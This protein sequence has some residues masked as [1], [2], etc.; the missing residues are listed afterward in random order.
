MDAQEAAPVAS[1]LMSPEVIGYVASAVFLC[2]L[3]PQ[4]VRLARTGVPDGVSPLAAMNGAIGDFGWVAYGLTA[5]LVP[6]WGVS[7]LALIPGLWTVALLRREASRQDLVGAGLWVGFIVAAG[8]T[9]RLGLVLGGTVLVSLAPQLWRVLRSDDL[10]GIAPATWWIAIGDAALWGLYGVL[11]HD[12][13]LMLYAGI[14]LSIAIT[15]LVR[16]WWTRT[17]VPAVDAAFVGA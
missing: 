12:P 1:R 15:V 6:V 16:L 11:E 10:G 17:R 8:M 14:L 7:V 9:G 13:A 4:P 2:R 5:G 3:L